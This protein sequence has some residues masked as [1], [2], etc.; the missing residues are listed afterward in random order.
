MHPEATLEATLE[1]ASAACPKRMHYGPCGGVHPGGGCEVPGRRCSFVD[2]DDDVLATLAF[3]PDEVAAPP[4]GERDALRP[5]DERPAAAGEFAALAAAGGMIT[6]DLNARGTDPGVF[7]EAAA[8]LSGLSAVVAGEP[9]GLHDTLSP[10]H[11]ALV[12]SRHGARV[13]AGLTCRDRNRVALE[14]ELAALADIGVAGVLAVTGDHPASTVRPDAAGVFD[15]DSTRLAALVRRAGLFCAVA[16]QPSAAPV[17]YRPARLAMKVRAGAELCFLNLCGGADEVA[18]FA[19]AAR[20][21]GAGVPL[22]ANVPVVTSPEAAARLAAL[23]GA[24]LPPAIASLSARTRDTDEPATHTTRWAAVTPDEG[25]TAAVD[26]AC[27]MLAVPGV[28]GVH[29]SAIGSP[30]DVTGLAATTIVARTAALI[31][32][33]LATGTPA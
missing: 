28:A 23:P 12:L 17:S 22:V 24:R 14:G 8:L 4:G 27:A 20:G 3:S 32:A 9:P 2:L 19:S 16:E 11:K 30:R 33:R 26:L 13:I 7:A 15:L 10:A 1:R 18:A 21:A 6:T 31:R 5:A 25:I 29:L